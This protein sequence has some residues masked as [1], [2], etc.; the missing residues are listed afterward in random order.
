[1]LT[2][3]KEKV[4]NIGKYNCFGNCYVIRGGVCVCEAGE[5]GQIIR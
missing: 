3:E 4:S 2:F 1:M 5:N